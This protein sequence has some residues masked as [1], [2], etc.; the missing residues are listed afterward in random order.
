MGKVDGT[1]KE[2]LFALIEGASTAAL[3]RAL[4]SITKTRRCR[5]VRQ[6]EWTPRRP[7]K[8]KEA[9]GLVVKGIGCRDVPVKH[10][11]T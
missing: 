6:T 11:I 9:I 7:E 8:S 10:A 5:A 2:Q 3:R 1:L 4:K